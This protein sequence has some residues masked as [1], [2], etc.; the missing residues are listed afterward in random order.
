MNSKQVDRGDRTA[1]VLAGGGSLGAVQIGMLQALVGRVQIHFVVGSSV[2]AINAA[3]FAM[4]PTPGGVTTLV[5]FW[6]QVRRRNV[7][8]V[9]PR[10]DDSPA[11]GWPGY[12]IGGALNTVVRK[13]TA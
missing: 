6:Q 2:G 12:R 3:H 8:P 10:K 9:S 13:P 1:L 4:D 5:Q 7:F 11:D